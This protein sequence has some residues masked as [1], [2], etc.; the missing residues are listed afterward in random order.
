MSSPDL[1][2]HVGLGKCGSSTI[3]RDVFQHEDGYLGTAP[4]IDDRLN[5][6]KRLQHC[7][8]FAGRQTL[9]RSGLRKWVKHVL[10]MQAELWPDIDRLIL[11]NEML[12]TSNRISDRPILRVLS[13]LQ[14]N[15]WPGRVR[16]V[17]VLRNQATRLASSYAQGS[18]G[19][20]KANQSDF[21]RHVGRIMDKPRNRR[22]FDYSSY[23]EG[24]K[25]IVGGR[26]LCILLIE[27]TH[28]REFWSTLAEFCE[29]QQFDPDGMLN[30]SKEKKN[31]RSISGQRWK[32]SRYE[33][34]QSA[35]RQVDHWLNLL[36][37]RR[38]MA[39][40]RHSVRKHTIEL[41]TAKFS[42]S[43][44]KLNGEE[45]DESISLTPVV[46]RLIEKRCGPFN[47][48][49]GHQLGKNLAD[50]GYFVSD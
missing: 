5:F 45:S 16:V 42:K 22:L 31:K 25:K 34:E 48:A 46:R 28:T 23:V 39:R 6:A 14:D 27:E 40:S 10:E 29:L 47:K 12:S 44:L 2:L 41:L 36:W 35:K 32:L 20:P 33:P 18:A 43:E 17:L 8:P 30:A 50:L 11:S 1:I 26:D 3:Q 13:E 49:L 7:T 24:L 9:S 4:R 21:E 38:L 37:S 15:L 19:N